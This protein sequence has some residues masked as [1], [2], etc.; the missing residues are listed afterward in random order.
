MTAPKRRWR[1]PWLVVGLLAGFAVAI[2]VS[3]ILNTSHERFLMTWGPFH[4]AG[5]GLG[6][7]FLIDLYRQSMGPPPGT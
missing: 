4:F 3:P 1:F 6:I 2:I 5:V 7:G